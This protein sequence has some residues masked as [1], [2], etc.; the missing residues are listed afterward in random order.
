MLTALVLATWIGLAL[1]LFG[2]GGSMLSVAILSLTL[3][4]P[5]RVAI[6]ASLLI[7]GVTSAAAL[8]AQR[9]SGSVSVRIG[10]VFGG[11]GMI[12]AFAGGRLAAS[13][14][15]AVLLTALGVMVLFTSIA[16]LRPEPAAGA[17]RPRADEQKPVRVLRILPLALTIGV[18]TG[19]LG[20]GGGFLLVPALVFHA[21]LPLKRA[22]ATSFVAIAL[23]SLAGFAAHLDQASLDWATVVPF[24]L[25]ATLGSV[26][27]S[28]L[29]K[30]APQQLLRRGFAALVCL[31]AIVVV[32]RGLPQSR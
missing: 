24:T 2:G 31:V 26:A 32:V 27:G 11:A 1:G 17:A 23:Q 14:P 16:M 10:L 13:I 21:R 8:I 7:N 5:A 12:G 20:A 3:G 15:E 6:T 9:G 22:I 28:A 29:A 4:M 19:M 30:R 18:V 25:M